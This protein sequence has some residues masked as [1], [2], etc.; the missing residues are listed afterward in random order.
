MLLKERFH[1]TSVIV[2]KNKNTPLIILKWGETI[3]QRFLR[4]GKGLH[5]AGLLAANLR[6][7][8]IEES[9][10][11][12]EEIRSFLYYYSLCILLT[13][14]QQMDYFLFKNSEL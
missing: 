1:E 9:L 13:F 3:N 11:T 2:M 5:L 4:K 7:K 6:W 8:I 14:S 10:K 12:E